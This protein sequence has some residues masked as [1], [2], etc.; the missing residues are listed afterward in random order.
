MRNYFFKFEDISDSSSETLGGV[1][2]TAVIIDREYKEGG[3][4]TDTPVFHV[5]FY[6]DDWKSDE[7]LA[8]ER[9][10]V[11][12]NYESKSGEFWKDFIL[13]PLDEAVTEED[14]E[15]VLCR[16]ID[17]ANARKNEWEDVSF[18]EAHPLFVE[19]DL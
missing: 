13:K 16:L 15:T 7:I 8:A 2:R 6:F 9:Y 17:H 14:V 12:S 18:H 19:I 1:E 4:V 11:T 3:V 5:N 10:E